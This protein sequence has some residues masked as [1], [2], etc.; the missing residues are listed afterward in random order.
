MD[1]SNILEDMS[2]AD[3]TNLIDAN[4]ERKGSL[5]IIPVVTD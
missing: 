4:F 2:K 5:D 3:N 1:A